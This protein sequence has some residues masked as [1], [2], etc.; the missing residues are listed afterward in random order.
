MVI[1]LVLSIHFY[2]CLVL[3]IH[4][5]ACLSFFCV[6]SFLQFWVQGGDLFKS[7]YWPFVGGR[8]GTVF[9]TFTQALVS[10]SS[11]L[12]RLLWREVLHDYPAVIGTGYQEVKGVCA[13]MAVLNSEYQDAHNQENQF[14]IGSPCGFG[15]TQLIW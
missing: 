7:I 11:C 5:S 8:V 14:Y 12:P 13:G 1:A 3:L 2:I 9:L 6:V 4:I 10:C 15:L